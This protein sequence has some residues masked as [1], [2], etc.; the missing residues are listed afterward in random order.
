MSADLPRLVSVDDHV[1]E[2]PHVWRDNV[3]AKHRDA[4]PAIVRRRGRVGKGRSSRTWVLEEDAEAPWAD[5]WSYDGSLFPILRSL[6]AAGVPAGTDLSGAATFDDLR[7]GC[8]DR[9]ARLVDLDAN[10]TDASLCFP[11]F[12]R[13]CGQTFLEAADHD[14]AAACVHAYNDWMIDDWC[15]DDGHGRL[16]PLTLVPLWDADLAA[17]EVRRCAEKGSHAVCFTEGPTDLGLPSVYTDCW[18]P[19]W[20]ACDETATVVNMHVGSSS[21]F[22]TTSPDAPPLVSIGLTHEGTEHALVDWL[23]S[24]I[25]ARY[26]T[27]KVALSE[28]QAGW[29]PYVLERLDRSYNQWRGRSGVEERIPQPPSTYVPGRVYACIFDDNAGLAM[30]DRIGMGQ[31]MFETDYPHTDSTW[32]ESAGV[33]ARLVA[34]AGLDD[35]EV[36]RLLRANAVECYGLERYGIAP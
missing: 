17:A 22:L 5:C 15:G 10:H 8:Y 34:A 9:A 29:M 26:P 16:V 7:P 27:L 25:L 31:L 11:T 4:A 30:R 28:G 13:F 35:D 20:H 2:P 32:P 3:P 36:R 18:E 24:G 19:L 6:A 1:I 21:K 23:C 33:A 14:V 12:P